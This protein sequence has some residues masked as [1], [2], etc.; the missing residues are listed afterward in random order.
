MSESRD[1]DLAKNL[2]LLGQVSVPGKGM[3]TSSSS[4]STMRTQCWEFYKNVVG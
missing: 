4:S 2:Q 1:D 3:P